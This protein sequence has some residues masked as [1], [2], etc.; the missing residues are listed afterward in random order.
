MVLNEFL[1]LLKFLL[2]FTIV[3]SICLGLEEKIETFVHI[4]TPLIF[5][6]KSR[7]ASIFLQKYFFSLRKI[8]GQKL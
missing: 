7:N 6:P 1:K 3:L 5:L 4:L 8:F 2:Q